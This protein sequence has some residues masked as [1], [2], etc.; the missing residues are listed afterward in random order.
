[1]KRR[2]IILLTGGAFVLATLAVALIIHIK[3]FRNVCPDDVCHS[4]ECVKISSQISNYMNPSINPCDNFYQFVCGSFIKDSEINDY[5][6]EVS[7]TTLHDEKINS[8][9]KSIFEDTIDHNEIK[10]FVLTKSYYKVCMDTGSVEENEVKIMHDHLE[11][12][13]GWP[14]LEDRLWNSKNFDWF[15]YIYNFRQLGLT[16]DYILQLSVGH[17]YK[18]TTFHILQLDQPVL[19]IPPAFLLN[20]DDN[21][22]LI[23]TYQRYMINVAMYLG[24][25]EYRAVSELEEVLN[26]EIQLAEIMEDEKDCSNISNF[27]NIMTVKDLEREYSTIPWLE[28]INNVIAPFVE[29]TSDERILILRPTYVKKL[30]NLLQLT[31]KRTQINYI[32][33]KAIESLIP[34]LNDDLRSFSLKFKSALHGVSNN[35]PRWKECVEEVYKNF[36]LVSS[37]QYVDKFPVDDIEERISELIHNIKMEYIATIEAADWINKEVK[38]VT[39]V[40]LTNLKHIIGYSQDLLNDKK[41]AEVFDNAHVFPNEYLRSFLNI[42][43]AKE[44]F[45]YKYL[46][47]LK[48]RSAWLDEN[49]GIKEK[50]HYNTF[51]NTIAI[52]PG[53]VRQ[54]F[55]DVRHPN[56]LNYGGI[57]FEISREISRVFFEFAHEYDENENFVKSKKGDEYG[58]RKD[59]IVRQYNK[60]E[61]EELENK[62]ISGERTFQN[63]L[64]DNYGI[65]LAYD[66]YLRW[67]Q[68]NNNEKT[69]PGLNYNPVQLF[70]ISFSINHCSVMRNESFN[71]ATEVNLY[72]PAQYRII[73]SLTNIN[74]FSKDFDCSEESNM[75]SEEQCNLW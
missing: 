15:Y 68:K 32:V 3:F 43:L 41:F 53:I 9:L 31:S 16:V 42:S 47:E 33:W 37:I 73:G 2:W 5:V 62:T 48:S 45:K 51:T 28:Y 75:Y 12:V 44:N 63:N 64:G 55:F 36:P 67:S 52:G 35:K 58:T 38:Q 13:G 25:N 23:E 69:L 20:M 22:I 49:I 27:Y 17:D 39:V 24:A 56:Y 66:A 71:V 26:F 7:A 40:K 74:D 11:K 61:V 65:K 10:S 54:N 30:E 1:M 29:I 50:T 4:P 34:Y 46:R 8:E 19:T 18:N 6:R 70:W 59:C 72:A 57:G 21:R 14:V 60:Y